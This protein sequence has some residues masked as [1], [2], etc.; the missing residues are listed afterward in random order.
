M[1]ALPGKISCRFHVTQQN[2]PICEELQPHV[3]GMRNGT[4]LTSQVLRL[5][6]SLRRKLNTISASVHLPT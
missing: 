5:I 6:T 4:V 1:S 2:S 3:T